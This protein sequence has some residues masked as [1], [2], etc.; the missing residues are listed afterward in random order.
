VG[1]MYL[2][3]KALAVALFI[4]LVPIEV[5][6]QVQLFDHEYYIEKRQDSL[7][8]ATDAT[9]TYPNPDPMQ[10]LA[11]NLANDFLAIKLFRF[12][13][14]TFELE[15]VHRNFLIPSSANLVYIITHIHTKMAY[16]ASGS[17][18]DIMNKIVADI[19]QIP[20]YNIRYG[21]ND[22]TTNYDGLISNFAT[23]SKG[24]RIKGFTA[25]T[26]Q[27]LQLGLQTY[28]AKF[29]N[30]K[31]QSHSGKYFQWYLDYLFVSTK[32]HIYQP[33]SFLSNTS[34]AQHQGWSYLLSTCS[35]IFVYLLNKY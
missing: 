32:E 2:L 6:G 15:I 7:D 20:Q 5:Q 26:L 22:T 28:M 12:G 8:S 29:P 23:N 34:S 9:L 21:S 30:Y 35:I 1:L 16:S 33:S 25:T 14:G 11:R 31:Q 17:I 4:N 19:S 18:V 27:Q 13:D 3:I 10:Y 24:V